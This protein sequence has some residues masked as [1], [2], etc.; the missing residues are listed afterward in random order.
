MA[1]AL[2]ETEPGFAATIDRCDEILAAVWGHGLKTVLFSDTGAERLNR[3]EYTQPALF[4]IEVALAQLLI[5]WGVRPGAVMGHSVG[6][7]AA[8]CVAGVFS[9]ED[10]LKLIAARARLMQSLPPGGGMVAV[11]AAEADVART[12]APFPGL[13]VAALNGPANVV[14]SG[15]LA[16]IDRLIRALDA[17]GAMYHQLTVSHAFHSALMDPMLDALEREADGI[18]HAEPA[19]P[20]ISNLTGRRLQP[21]EL[22]GGAYW[23]AHA[24]KPVRFA[25]GMRAL[26]ALD[27]GAFVEIG[28][29]P[30]LLGMA[31]RVLAD[32]DILWLPTLKPGRGDLDQLL[33]SVGKLYES[34]IDLDFA[35]MA[36]PHARR[37]L[38]IPTYPF[39]KSRYWPRIKPRA[40]NAAPAPEAC[41]DWLYDLEWRPSP[42]DAA[43]VPAPGYIPDT[44]LLGTAIEERL[45]A[46][47]RAHPGGDDDRAYEEIDRLC[48]DYIVEAL[49]TLGCALRIGD[50]FSTDALRGRL[51]VLDRHGRL[52]ARLMM[53]LAE[54][55][56]LESDGKAWRVARVP[57]ERL[58]I[59]TAELPQFAT[60]LAVLE[61]CG[62]RLAEVLRGECDPMQLLFPGGSLDA[63][64]E[65]Y[66]EPR[67][68]RV[69][70][71]L[72]ERCIEAVVGNLPPDRH[73]GVLEVGGGTGGTTARIL[74]HFPPER[75]RYRFTDVSRQFL[76]R[77]RARFKDH[78]FIDYALFDLD[79]PGLDNPAA[80]MAG[81]EGGADIVI[82]ANVVHATRDLRRSLGTLRRCLRPGGLLVLLEVVRPQRL[83]DLTVGLTDGWWA[84]EDHDIR[85]DYALVTGETWTRILDQTGFVG[86]LAAPALGGGSDRLLSN[87]RVILAKRG[88]DAESPSAAARQDAAGRWLIFAD[89]GGLGRDLAARLRARGGACLIVHPGDDYR[90]RGGDIEIRPVVAADHARVVETFV[91]SDPKAC[92]GVVYLWGL[93]AVFRDDDGPAAVLGA[94]EAA[95]RP[96]LV[97]I[98]A[99]AATGWRGGGLTVATRGGRSTE[100]TRIAAHPAQA[101]LW[102][103]V[104]TAA[105]EH[106]ELGCRRI[107]LS[108]GGEAE[109][110]LEELLRNE[111]FENEI[112]LT[113]DGR[114]VLR[115]ERSP[116]S[117][118]VV[119]PPRLRADGAYLVTGGLTGLGLETA[120]WL[121]E[122]GAGQLILVGRRAPDETARAAM[123]RIGSAN[124]AGLGK[125]PICLSGDIGDARDAERILAAVDATGLEL[126]GVIHSAGI[127]SD[128]SLLRQD[129]PRFEAVLRAKAA[130]A[131]NLHRLTRSRTLDFFVLYSSGAAILGSVGQAN[132]AAANAFMDSLAFHRSALGLPAL[133]INWAA[134]RD[135]GAAAGH[136]VLETTRQQG[137]DPI[138]VEGGLT[139][140]GRM[141]AS[142]GVRTAVLPIDWARLD[143][144][145][146]PILQD[147]RPRPAA[148]GPKVKEATPSESVDWRKM[149]DGGM[150]ALRKSMLRG[151]LEEEAARLLKLSSVQLI[152]PGQPLRDLGLDSLV[153]LEFRNSIAM[154][155]SVELPPTLLYNYP[156]IDLLTEHLLDALSGAAAPVAESEPRA[157]PDDMS[158]EDLA[159]LLEEQ[160]NLD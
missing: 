160:I 115:L 65:L 10:G 104:G 16:E 124:I 134:W 86:A 49:C 66:S 108:G 2:Y 4:A 79:N 141:M 47:Y 56:I 38:S 111:T 37:K 131:W 57:E 90:D 146:R 101:A 28:P 155:L 102:G 153:S 132:H 103:M 112:A 76:D 110:L 60:E 41:R 31:R 92:R 11:L 62:A 73:L 45:A 136:P 144:P 51:G 36:R 18:P 72:I 64:T 42:G 69:F 138:D 50:V 25:D 44:G 142:R 91:Q 137:V 22:R 21:G 7:Y 8:A 145:T 93:D 128:A 15:P 52:F 6:E 12:I 71:G 127:V 156:T 143:G 35:A 113:P 116:S 32:P 109:G 121:A 126:A 150:P 158:E 3:T 24:R 34:G 148:D 157:D 53:I 58:R 55:G 19:I 39:E 33:E 85:P 17:S 75:T 61:P 1:R 27:H 40:A 133:S 5:S 84:F 122:H 140:L 14:V 98:Q 78:D 87:Q 54:D 119:S 77:A 94:V 118:G 100:R 46:S 89:R 120:R 26:R 83:G 95:C 106:P 159:R 97:A 9:L 105:L 107:D 29:A 48:R 114:R 123:A 70:N 152:D 67:P 130:G 74:R 20:I 129:W 151:L 63:V 43:A 135:I 59:V 82:A 117:Q 23:C 139:A 80:D 96:G 30:I 13:A 88:P 149:L 68:V 147:V 99:M 125:A 81:L 154:A